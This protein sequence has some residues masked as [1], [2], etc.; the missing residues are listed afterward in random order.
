MSK[1]LWDRSGWNSMTPTPS[2]GLTR[3]SNSAWSCWSWME[4]EAWW[5]PCLHVDYVHSQD[6]VSSSEHASNV[7]SLVA[8]VTRALHGDLCS[9]AWAGQG[10]AISCMTQNTEVHREGETAEGTMQAVWLCSFTMQTS[11]KMMTVWIN[12]MLSALSAR[13]EHYK[14]I[15]EIC[16][17]IFSFQPLKLLSRG[18]SGSVP[19]APL[20]KCLPRHP[21]HYLVFFSI[22]LP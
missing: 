20:L 2:C 19:S 18:S 10:E 3:S 6:W 9:E 17:C 4:T 5:M 8:S 21:S 14:S 15:L 13:T 7:K 22:V 16:P 11:A 12:N 1:P